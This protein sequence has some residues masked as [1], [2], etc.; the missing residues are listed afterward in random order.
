MAGR[1]TLTSIYVRFTDQTELSPTTRSKRETVW[2]L[3]VEPRLGTVP[4]AKVTENAVTTIRDAPESP[5]GRAT[6]P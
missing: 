2:R 3:H 6:R 5:A 4:V 1:E